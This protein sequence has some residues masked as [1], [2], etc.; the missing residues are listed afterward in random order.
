M[1]FTART[2]LSGII[3]A[4]AFG[5]FTSSAN[6]LEGG[7]TLVP[8]VAFQYKTLD[9]SQEFVGGSNAGVSGDFNA[10]LPTINLALTALYQK[11][12]VSLKYDTSFSDNYTEADNG[13]TKANSEVERNDFSITFGYNVWKGLSAFAGYMMG[14]TTVTPDARY[15][16]NPGAQQN[17]SLCVTTVPC[18]PTVVSNLAKDHELLNLADYEQEYEEK[19][20]FLGASYGLPVQ[21][22][23]TLSFSL[24]YALMDGKYTDNYLEGTAN[25]QA[26]NYEGDSKGYSLGLTWSAPLTDNSGYF[27]DIRRQR[28]DMDADDKTPIFDGSVKTEE[29]MM[30]ATLGMQMYF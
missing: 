8:Q 5:G 29:T 20:F 11:A 10:T 15:I 6:A 17:N 25:P 26:F 19:G 4:T 18:F 12:Y 27:V 3:A 22:I 7:I 2:A 21:Q 9:F 30:T 24:A 28:Y 14:K 13:F 1:K 16:D 23:G